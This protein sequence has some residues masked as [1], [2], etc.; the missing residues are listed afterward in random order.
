[1]K[2]APTAYFIT[3]NS[4]MR[5]SQS[6]NYFCFSLLLFNDNIDGRIFC[7]LSR[8]SVLIYG[9]CSVYCWVLKAKKYIYISKIS[10]RRDLENVKYSLLALQIP[11]PKE[12]SYH[13]LKN[14][15]NTLINLKFIFFSCFLNVLT[16]S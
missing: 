3:Y 4:K 2:I 16:R 1:M 13:T 7:L 8:L 9:C 15:T 14:K 6:N 11:I 12:K 10:V 5:Y